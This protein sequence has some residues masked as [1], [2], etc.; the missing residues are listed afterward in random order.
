MTN[1]YPKN[2]VGIKAITWSLTAIIQF[3]AFGL[4]ICSFFLILIIP[5]FIG[6]IVGFLLHI[7]TLGYSTKW[8]RH[9]YP[10][11]LSK[12]DSFL[13]WYDNSA[14]NGWFIERLFQ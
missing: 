10:S 8:F 12:R 9:I 13:K 4:L 1:D 11:L 2:S 6:C 14:D 7:V 5:W 3:T